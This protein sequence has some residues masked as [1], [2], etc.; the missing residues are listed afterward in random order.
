[1]TPDGL[2]HGWRARPPQ[3]LVPAIALTFMVVGSATASC[4]GMAMTNVGAEGGRNAPPKRPNVV[5]VMTDDQG[6][7]DFSFTGNPVLKTPSFDAFARQAVRL[8]DFHVAPMCSPTRG[9]LISGLAALRNGATSVT[10]GRTFMRTDLPT[11]PAAFRQAGYRTGL[12]GKWHLGDFYP[13]RPMDKGFDTAVYHL[14][15]GQLQSTPEFDWPLFDGRLFR[16]GVEERYRGHCTDVWFDEA[17][18]W[19]KR[20]AEKNE[21]F[22]CYL[23]T[24]APHGP[25]LDEE[26]YIAPYR[27]PNQPAAFF[28]MIAHV[29]QRFGDL[30]RFL[31]DN[32][33]ADDTIVVVMTDNG[34]TAGVRLYNAG[35]RAGKTT[36]Y[37]GG[38]RVPCWIRWPSGGLG[39]PRDLNPPTQIMDLFPTFADFCGLDLPQREPEDA[40]FAG[41]S[42][43]PLL[44]GDVAELPSRALVVQYGQIVK[45]FDS[46]VIK[47][48]WRLVKGTE[49]YDVESD[50]AQKTDLAE[51]HPDV[52]A[53]LKADYEEWWRAVEPWVNQFVPIHLGAAAQEVVELTSGDWE[54]IYADNTGFVRE[55]VGGP[56]GG[57]WNVLIERPATYEFILRRWPEQT[58]AAIGSRYPPNERSP[59]NRPNLQT[60]GFPTIA[61]AHL[62]VGDKTARANADPQVNGAPVRIELPAGPARLKAWFADKDGRALCG[63]F[64][65]TVRRLEDGDAL[66]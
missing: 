18:A 20:C 56:D 23:P 15:W 50:L 59:A 9:Q 5:I 30:D 39:Q 52:L 61:Q 63:A 45:K 42:L 8:T 6:L 33:L 35:L 34:G 10:A 38:H 36:Y 2:V 12:F 4:G 55:A 62:T 31:S 60:K 48:R 14:G 21:P 57:H 37:E 16:N 54:G 1:M 66:E 17:M 40:R 25:H 51:R 19:M 43:A 44:R 22:F 32:G 47:G 24:N 41:I 64:F 13:H 3:S 28:G 29:D 53:E 7:G 11:L 26:R 58:G 46:C 65:V 27:K 49:L